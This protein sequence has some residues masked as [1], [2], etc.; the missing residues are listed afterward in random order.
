M[1]LALDL[2]GEETKVDTE[3]NAATL[4]ETEHVGGPGTQQA[5][6]KGALTE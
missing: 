6:H 2:N 5:P 4:P 1:N 3:P